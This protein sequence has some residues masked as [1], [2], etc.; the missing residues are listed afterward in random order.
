[1]PIEQ[2]SCRPFSHRHGVIF[3]YDKTA[4]TDLLAWSSQNREA[5][6]LMLQR[7]EIVSVA[8]PGSAIHDVQASLADV[9]RDHMGALCAFHICGRFVRREMRFLHDACCQQSSS[10]R[11]SR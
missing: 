4:V 3:V 5:E 11:V 7:L 1:M 10:C 9:V 8:V 2:L 6:K